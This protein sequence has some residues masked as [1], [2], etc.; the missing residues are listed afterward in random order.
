MHWWP[1]LGLFHALWAGAE[2]CHTV[3]AQSGSRF[4][5]GDCF[6]VLSALLLIISQFL[7]SGL[8]CEHLCVRKA[9]LSLQPLRGCR[10]PRA[11]K[12]IIC[13]DKLSSSHQIRT[14]ISLC[15]SVSLS[16]DSILFADIVGFTS[17]A[18]QCTAQELVKLLNELFGKFDELATVSAT[19]NICSFH[20][21]HSVQNKVI[22]PFVQLEQCASKCL[23]N[24]CIS[25]SMQTEMMVDGHNILVMICRE[26]FRAHWRLQ[27]KDANT[28]ILSELNV[29]M[30]VFPAFTSCNVSCD[31]G[32]IQ[33]VYVNGWMK[34]KL[35]VFLIVSVSARDSLQWGRLAGSR[36]LVSSWLYECC[37][38]AP[39]TL[40]EKPNVLFSPGDNL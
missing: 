34:S 12:K 10:E 29:R 13:H 26:V 23:F 33:R 2:P 20:V 17:L 18:S 27:K 3:K 35:V 37:S 36:Q 40:Q 24:S 19:T 15:L 14:H 4:S 11:E 25:L 1:F 28:G 39:Q 30:D 21:L 22:T 8:I 38:S 32:L 6:M 16:P 31:T 7:C 9:W 5:A